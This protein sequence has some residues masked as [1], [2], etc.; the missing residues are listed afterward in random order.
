MNVIPV[1]IFVYESTKEDYGITF[2]GWSYCIVR[3]NAIIKEGMGGCSGK[4]VDYRRV[5]L[6]ALAKALEESLKCTNS[7]KDYVKVRLTSKYLVNVYLKEYWKKWIYSQWYDYYKHEEI[8]YS[9]EWL[10]IIPFFKNNRYTFTLNDGRRSEFL[11]KCMDEAQT[12]CE[13]FRREWRGKPDERE[14]K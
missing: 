13:I 2:G 3:D 5:R 12:A 7:R 9:R 1:E 6:V 14:I 4:N 11:Y 10:R 8:P